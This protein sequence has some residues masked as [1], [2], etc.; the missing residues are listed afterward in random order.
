MSRRIPLSE[1]QAFDDDYEAPSQTVLEEAVRPVLRMVMSRHAKYQTIRRDHL[2][3]AVASSGT[4]R[5]KVDD[6]TRKV[7]EELQRVFG[8]KLAP[9]PVKADNK[10]RKTAKRKRDEQDPPAAWGVVSAL[11][12][13]ARGVLAQLFEEDAAVQVPNGRNTN[14]QQFYVPR[15]TKSATPYSN[16]ELVK[17]GLCLLVVALLVVAE[18]HMVEDDL[19]EVLAQFGVLAN[20][21]HK[22]PSTNMNLTELLGEMVKRDYLVREPQVNA[23]AALSLGAR[24]LMEFPPRLVYSVVGLVYGDKFDVD[25]QQ[26]TLVTIERAF[27]ES[28]VVGEA[29]DEAADLTERVVSEA[30]D[31]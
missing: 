16:Q 26:R 12:D 19:A 1:S 13:K 29:N 17:S 23:S 8:L 30:N 14:D 11:D 28:L 20:L 7:D 10:R 22:V 6:I 4:K 5:G 27:G 24:A 21:N 25:S 3:Q 9:M 2:L 15:H 31:G 18:N